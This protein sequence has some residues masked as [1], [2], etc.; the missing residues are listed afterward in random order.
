[1]SDVVILSLVEG[2]TCGTRVP[3]LQCADTLTSLGARPS[4]V[5]ARSDAEIDEQLARLSE[6]RLI[7]A[8]ESNSQLRHVVRRLV[9][10]HAP[11]PSK[12]PADLPA[13]RTIPDLP[14]IGVLPLAGLAFD[15]PREPDVVAKA[16]LGDAVQRLDLLRHDGGSVTLDGALLGAATDDGAPL[17]WRGRVA[18]DDV[19]LSDGEEPIIAVS[20]ANAGGTAQLDG[21]PLVIAPDA[22]D[23]LIDV[24]VAV[25][26]LHKPFLGKARLRYEVRRARGRAVAVTPREAELPIL[27]D[28]VPGVITRKR[29]WW[30][31]PAAWS[32]YTS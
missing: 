21:L 5:V 24:A 29:S 7:V 30:I 19:V 2:D 28:G 11:P 15:F 14:T 9:R 17:A 4:A 20:V 1:M 27:D 12:R 3:V 10:R 25:P 22:T 31:E 6:I 8:A 26:L 18:V 16:A 23:G 13:N 32:V